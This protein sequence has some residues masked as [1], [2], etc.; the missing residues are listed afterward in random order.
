MRRLLLIISLI[1]IIY[2]LPACGGSTEQV[3][4]I[5]TGS[6]S[7]DVSYP[8]GKE[9]Y[10]NAISTPKGIVWNL[11]PINTFDLNTGKQSEVPANEIKIQNEEYIYQDN[12]FKMNLL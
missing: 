4:T 12:V 5:K 6:T 9:R 7:Y 3:Y 11:V 10:F 8:P 2:L 1:S